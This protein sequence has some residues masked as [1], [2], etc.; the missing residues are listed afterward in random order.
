M[1]SVTSVLSGLL[2]IPGNNDCDITPPPP[3]SSSSSA[4]LS[5]EE[6]HTRAAAVG[7]ETSLVCS[8]G[9]P[10]SLIDWIVSQQLS[11]NPLCYTHPTFLQPLLSVGILPSVIIHFL[12]PIQS[13]H[14]H[15][16]W[17]V[18]YFGCPL[19]HPSHQRSR[20]WISDPLLVGKT[21]IEPFQN[22][23]Q[24]QFTHHQPMNTKRWI[25]CSEWPKQ[26]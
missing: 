1:R 21:Y 10:E 2:S 5:H 13:L 12:L 26:S 16:P 20:L 23:T 25:H 8:I 17:R 15:S 9:S 18:S 3:S 24:N 14:F 4:L 19:H 11:F 7:Y 22:P 6:Y